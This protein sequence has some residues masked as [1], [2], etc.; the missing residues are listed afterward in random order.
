MTAQILVVWHSRTGG[1]AGLVDAVVEGVALVGD[2]V[3]VRTCP[4]L[5]VTVADVIGAAGIVIAT[6]ENFGYLSGAV[7]EFFDRVYDECR[8]QTRDRPYALV[9]KASNDG[10]GAV[11]A[12]QRI[13][14]GLGWRAIAEP[15]V[16]VG[17][18]EAHHLD[19]CRELGATMA[20][21]LDAGLW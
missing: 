15:V 8:D 16:V 7:K 20:A 13:I 1:T 5:D 10:T 19:A 4:A 2:S 6:P 3:S 14:T 21:G 11:R 12:A 18:T 9:V 17:A